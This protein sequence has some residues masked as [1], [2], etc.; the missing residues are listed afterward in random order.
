MQG[1]EKKLATAKVNAA[2][3]GK[4]QAKMQEAEAQFK[5]AMRALPENQE[6]PSLLTS[7]SKSGQDVGLEFLLFEP[8][9]ETRQE[10]YAE[11]PVAMSLRGDY[12]NLAVFF[13]KVARLSRIVNI[14]NITVTPGKDGR[15]LNTACTAVTYKFV[16][17]P[18]EK[19]AAPAKPADRPRPRRPSRGAASQRRTL[20]WISKPPELPI[21]KNSIATMRALFCLIAAMLLLVGCDEPDKTAA[22]PQTVRK[23]ITA[24]AETGP[25]AATAV[26]AAGSTGT[27][28]RCGR[29]PGFGSSGQ[30]AD[31]SIGSRAAADPN[32][33]TRR[34]PRRR[35]RP[36]CCPGPNRRPI[37]PPPTGAKPLSL[38]G[39][40]Q[41]SGMAAADSQI[42]ALLNIQAPP[43]YNPKGKV[44]PFEPL[45]RDESAA[46]AVA[47]LRAK[48]RPEPAEN[49]AGKD[50]PGPAETGGH[51][52]GAGRQP[53]PGGR[54]LGQGIHHQRRH[55][56]RAELGEGGRHQS[57]Q[58]PRRGRVRRHLW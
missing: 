35:L 41:Q 34:R 47:K 37:H 43:P 8:K 52:H 2:E 20:N 36:C 19:P 54:V 12:H 14:N 13:D 51:Y 4:F 46:A 23:K 44:D 22:Q 32:R 5:I 40:P 39:N 6:I 24:K 55:L 26:A 25:P 28:S 16:E 58:S 3:L 30:A 15:E 38:D 53:G 18:P 17:P 9:P 50:R 10:F 7:V 1:L 56:H 42:A 29:E 33:R 31:A 49:P 27:C 11:I 57:R 21:M 45:L 48:R